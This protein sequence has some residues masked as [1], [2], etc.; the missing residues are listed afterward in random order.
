VATILAARE[1]VIIATGEHKRRSSGAR[2][3]RGRPRGRGDVP[4]AAPEHDV[5][6]RRAAA[7]ELTRVATPW[8]LDEVRWTPELI[9]RAVVWLSLHTGKGHPQAHAARLRRAPLSSLVA[10]YG[11]ARAR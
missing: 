10:R 4:P 9:V 8:L 6:R 3:G 7:A 1:I 11:L 2:R 5:L